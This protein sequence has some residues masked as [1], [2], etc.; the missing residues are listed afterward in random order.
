MM[1]TPDLEVTTSN[2]EQVPWFELVLS[3]VLHTHRWC[4]IV[5]DDRIGQWRD[6]QLNAVLCTRS[7]Q[8]WQW[9]DLLC[10]ALVTTMMSS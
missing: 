7:T 6:R 3:I 2:G 9:V 10:D 1:S 4:Q 5:L 8:I